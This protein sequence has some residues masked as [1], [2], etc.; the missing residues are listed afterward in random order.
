RI[1]NLIGG[2]D[3]WTERAG[4]GEILSRSHREFLIVAH[5]AVDEAGV[6]GDVLERALDRDMA[7]TA[8]DDDRKLAL[9]VEALRHHG[10]N[11]LA[12]VARQRVGEADGHARRV[13]PPAARPRR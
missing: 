1:G 7:A 2:D 3:P 8:S 4:G 5:A 12:V 10:A 13:R 11:H 9:E 6:A